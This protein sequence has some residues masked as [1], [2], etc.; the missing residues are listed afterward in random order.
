MNDDDHKSRLDAMLARQRARNSRLLRYRYKEGFDRLGIVLF[1][2]FALVF[3]L[4]WLIVNEPFALPP[5]GTPEAAA[6]AEELE[7]SCRTDLEAALVLLCQERVLGAH[8]WAYY[9][10][11]VGLGGGGGW[12]FGLLIA[13][14]VLVAA[15]PVTRWVARGFRKGRQ[16]PPEA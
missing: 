6:I 15:W 1:A 8:R 16:A 7:S 14:V 12:M 3:G 13:V 9:S 2:L 4:A 10:G 11:A 5:P